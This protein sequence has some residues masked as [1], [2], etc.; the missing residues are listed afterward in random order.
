[1]RVIVNLACQLV[2]MNV[3][4]LWTVE[5]M[6]DILFVLAIQSTGTS[7]GSPW[8]A[9]LHQWIHCV[10]CTG[11]VA[12]G[13]SGQEDHFALSWIGGEGK[14][15]LEDYQV[16]YEIKLWSIK[17]KLMDQYL[18]EAVSRA[19][20]I[21]MLMKD[22][23]HWQSLLQGHLSHGYDLQSHKSLQRLVIWDVEVKVEDFQDRGN[24]K[25]GLSPIVDSTGSAEQCQWNAE[26]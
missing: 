25:D 17:G 2:S 1:M 8:A 19:D 22:P 26:Y 3:R 11:N 5:E 15:L 13:V 20:D 4:A 18:A 14:Y 12:V 21:R 10:Q 9:H 6:Q 24:P 16:H 23:G 7:S